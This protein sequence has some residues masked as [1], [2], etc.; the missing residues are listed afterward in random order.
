MTTAP[1]IEALVLERS[2]KLIYRLVASAAVLFVVLWT[3][4]YLGFQSENARRVSQG[5]EGQVEYLVKAGDQFTMARLLSSLVDGGPFQAAAVFDGTGQLILAAPAGAE[6]PSPGTPARW[7]G[8]TRWHCLSGSNGR[9][10]SW[11]T[12]CVATRS[13]PWTALWAAALL[14]GCLLGL[15]LVWLNGFKR[16]SREIADPVAAFAASILASD[17]GSAGSPPADGDFG[18]DEVNRLSSVFRV[19]RL[20]SAEYDARARQMEVESAMNR[21]ATQVAHDIRSPLAALEVASGDAIHLP[22]DQRDL[23]R[24]AAERIRAIADGL[25][26]THRERP[27]ESDSPVPTALAPLIE[28]IVMEKRT[29]FRSRSG[30]FIELRLEG[31]ARALRAVVE[32]VEF[33]RLVS[34]LLNNAIEALDDGAG[35]TSAALLSRDGKV[36]LEIQDDGKGIPPEILARLG[37]A[38]ETHGKAQGTGLGLHHARASAES[39]G[40]TLEIASESGKGTV[41]SVTLPAATEGAER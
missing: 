40:G 23:I 12:V 5:L 21:V 24:S 29:Q 38:G 27:R 18:I 32:P 28:R 7:V 34:N 8:L 35:T 15:S 16:L 2:K 6:L 20:K 22:V 14:A 25:L 31:A 36:V 3:I 37:R 17:A 19:F 13:S 1:T 4:L 30:V 10:P 9:P 41:V 26:A 11:G 39:W 33:Q